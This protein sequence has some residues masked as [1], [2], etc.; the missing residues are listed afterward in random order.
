MVEIRS[1][2][3]LSWLHIGAALTAMVLGILVLCM[4]KG[5]LRHRRMGYGYLTCMLAVNASA[6]CL[7]KLFGFFGPFHVAA[8]VSLLT[9]LAGM[10]VA[11]R[12]DR[13]PGWLVTHL[14]Y[15]YWSV[16]GLYAAFFS[17]V[18]VRLPI[19][20]RFMWLVGG[21]TAATILF[22]ALMQ[23]RLTQR[24]SS[25]VLVDQPN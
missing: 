22:G 18:M 3:F 12:R 9:V 11:L 7:Y 5:T 8:V 16:I 17:E 4:R 10:R 15:M 19:P 2:T 14:T 25:E 1:Y 21:A 13:T 23:G 24:W 20:G 6:F